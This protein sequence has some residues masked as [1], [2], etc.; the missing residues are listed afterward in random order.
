MAINYEDLFYDTDKATGTKQVNKDFVKYVLQTTKGRA[1]MQDVPYLYTRYSQQLA[2]DERKRNGLTAVDYPSW[3][4]PTGRVDEG[5]QLLS[6]VNDAAKTYGIDPT[7][8]KPEVLAQ[9]V[10]QYKK[11]KLSAISSIRYQDE[12]SLAQTKA[13]LLGLSY[14]E[15]MELPRWTESSVLAK[16][17]QYANTPE[18]QQRKE[19]ALPPVS[20]TNEFQGTTGKADLLAGKLPTSVRYTQR[21]AE[22][23]ASLQADIDALVKADQYDETAFNDALKKYPT[24]S[25]MKTTTDSIIAYDKGQEE[26]TPELRA[27]QEIKG[28]TPKRPESY[29]NDAILADMGWSDTALDELKAEA[30]AKDQQ[31]NSWMKKVLRFQYGGLSGDAAKTKTALE[32]WAGDE[33]ITTEQRAE[34]RSAAGWNK[35][36]PA[37]EFN[38]DMDLLRK[39][40]EDLKSRTDTDSLKTTV[41]RNWKQGQLSYLYN[42]EMVKEM[43]GQDNMSAE[44]KELLSDEVFSYTPGST[45]MDIVGAT[46]A[47]VPRYYEGIKN[48]SGRSATKEGEAPIVTALNNLLARPGDATLITPLYN[49]MMGAAYAGLMD[50]GVA[51]TVANNLAPIQGFVDTVIEVAEF[52]MFGGLASKVGTKIVSK[53]ASPVLSKILA[54]IGGGASGFT[55]EL[56]EELIQE[57]NA[58]T[59]EEIGKA[60]TNEIKGRDLKQTDFETVKSRLFNTTGEAAKA[61]LP[62]AFGGAIGGFS[63]QANTK[64]DLETAVGTKTDSNAPKV[65]TSI[66]A[67]LNVSTDTKEALKKVQEGVALTTEEA[68]L[69]NPGNEANREAFQE[70]TKTVLPATNSGTRT[71]VQNV[72]AQKVAPAEVVTTEATPVEAPAAEPVTN[73]KYTVKKTGAAP[74]VKKATPSKGRVDL[75]PISYPDVTLTEDDVRKV[76]MDGL[77]NSGINLRNEDAK[78]FVNE[79]LDAQRSGSMEDF[80]RNLK[81]RSEELAANAAY[82][83]LAS[84]DDY[85]VY[86]AVVGR[87][88]F[89]NEKYLVSRYKGESSDLGEAKRKLRGVVS[90]DY[91]EKGKDEQGLDT[92][93]EEI[94]QTTGVNVGEKLDEIADNLAAIVNRVQIDRARKRGQTIR[95]L[96]KNKVLSQTDAYERVEQETRGLEKVVSGTGYAFDAKA[97]EADKKSLKKLADDMSREPANNKPVTVTVVAAES[98]RQQ[99]MSRFART[100]GLEVVYF[101]NTGKVQRNEFFDPDNSGRVFVNINAPA[102]SVEWAFGHGLFHALASQGLVDEIITNYARLFG[103]EE[104]IK[105]D[106][107]L[108]R[109]LEEEYADE[110]GNAMADPTFW[111]QMRTES[112]SLFDKVVEIVGKLLAALTKLVKKETDLGLSAT[113]VADFRDKTAAII[114][115]VSDANETVVK[116]LSDTNLL[117]SDWDGMEQQTMDIIDGLTEDINQNRGEAE[118]IAAKKE[119]R[120]KYQALLAEI[121]A[122]NLRNRT[123]KAV[124]RLIEY[125]TIGATSERA[126][127]RDR[128]NA[129]NTENKARMQ[130]RMDE[131]E[132]KLIDEL[133]KVKAEAKFRYAFLR[134]RYDERRIAD[135]AL[136]KERFRINAQR[137][138]LRETKTQIRHLGEKVAKTLSN[139]RYQGNLLTESAKKIMGAFV[140]D[141]MPVLR[142]RTYAGKM[143]FTNLIKLLKGDTVEYRDIEGKIV[144]GPPPVAAAVIVLMEDLNGRDI[145]N[146]D[147]DDLRYLNNIVKW[148]TKYPGKET[149]AFIGNKKEEYSK[150]QDGAIEK[151]TAEH[152]DDVTYE[153]AG[154]LRKQFSAYQQMNVERVAKTLLGTDTGIEYQLLGKDLVIADRKEAALLIEVDAVE[155]EM[156]DRLAKSKDRDLFSKKAK[157]WKS[158]HTTWED[159]VGKKEYVTREADVTLSRGEALV[160][161]MMSMNEKDRAA[162]KNGGKTWR[163]TNIAKLSDEAIDEIAAAVTADPELRWWRDKIMGSYDV[164]AKWANETA[165]AVFGYEVAQEQ[166]YYPIHRDGD[167]FAS[168]SQIITGT[169]EGMSMFTPRVKSSTKEFALR[170][171]METLLYAMRSAAKYSAFLLP[172]NNIKHFLLSPKLRNIVKAK[173]GPFVI[174]YYQDLLHNIEDGRTLESNT[175]KNKT[176][177]ITKVRENAT[178]A[179]LN[180]FLIP[181]RQLASYPLASGYLRTDY[182]TE[183]LFTGMGSKTDVEKMRQYAPSLYRRRIM[184]ASPEIVQTSSMSLRGVKKAWVQGR[185][186]GV[187]T[188]QRT[189]VFVTAKIWQAAKLQ[190]KG[191]NKNIDVNSEEYWEKV[192][193]LACTVAER[194]QSNYSLVLRTNIGSER[195]EWMKMFTMFTTDLDQLRGNLTDAVWDMR[196]GHKGRGARRLAAVVTTLATNVAINTLISAWRGSNDK[197]NEP[198]DEK[199]KILY[200]FMLEAMKLTF[201]GRIVANVMDGFT[202]ESIGLSVLED[203]ADSV[204]SI[205]ETVF[206]GDGEGKTWPLIR[207]AMDAALLTVGVSIKN[208]ERDAILPLLKTVDWTAYD[209]YARALGRGPKLSDYYDPLNAAVEKNDEEA[210]RQLARVIARYTV[211]KEKVYQEKKVTD[212]DAS[213]PRAYPYKG[214]EWYVEAKKNNM[215]SKYSALDT[216]YQQE[217]M[218]AGGTNP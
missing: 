25:D 42:I 68:G 62:A 54:T 49:E 160:F 74:D 100:L 117:Y 193:D 10:Q 169:L 94:M 4:D 84:E 198:E 31:E 27:L 133:E 170:D 211:E 210:I 173:T 43:N 106:S 98:K 137:A 23:Y 9:F 51:E 182:M 86:K 12:Q 26:L 186:M 52:A 73:Q 208:I 47:Q 201:A 63:E 118:E 13:K 20:Y 162:I 95:D 97:T 178:I 148:L 92:I 196:H 18:D 112:S 111:A 140:S 80:D 165:L 33:N 116:A 7:S 102:K 150:V 218:A 115:G 206:S 71:A 2:N 217:Y 105:T 55:G 88:Y 176:A 153:K 144:E 56:G 66:L 149:F 121:R 171:P 157:V 38:A 39:D 158:F 204:Y 87:R 19:L 120:G 17:Y 90:L 22:E 207:D 183:A 197:D 103:W 110:L 8:A 76:A 128:I 200:R 14:T 69:F 129:K 75:S 164:S 151:I 67:S 202:T 187:K 132:Q 89:V 72:T 205:G 107:G 78:L 28:E 146:F 3:Y 174:E 199:L 104:K 91:S 61:L 37:P 209:D 215:L 194:T 188:A 130:A 124:E 99:F 213:R 168:P 216:I 45:F 44:I 32:K 180:S 82:V 138:N 15:N 93:G 126:A 195:S 181:L 134:Q 109:D 83:D 60:V 50:N 156:L 113:E 41:L 172:V 155:Q 24:L 40:V 191:Q 21:L 127:M 166:F 167:Q 142:E 212:P 58:I 136:L 175:A 85:R 114:K 139:G 81:E 16:Y 36:A 145:K 154:V 108:R 96:D 190:V 131:R 29:A 161:A 163:Q 159:K 203:L 179:Y 35:F 59:W 5:S 46:T 1:S 30:A 119:A 189:D 214:S 192:A 77:K 147:A 11:D 143:D 65:N 185:F 53:V 122:S 101:K 135:K 48:I 141:I 184:G 152:K 6:Y 123:Q 57:I 79:L 70:V 34:R 125:R 177:L 64:T